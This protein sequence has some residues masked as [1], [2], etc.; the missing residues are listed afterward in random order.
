VSDRLEGKVALVTGANSGIGRAV[1]RRFAA[2]GAQVVITGR[3][4]AE[5]KAVA[6]EIGSAA[7]AV[8]ADS[9]S[10]E[11]LDSLFATVTERHGRLDIVVPNAGV[12]WLTPLGQITEDDYAGIFGT[13]VKGAIFTVQKALPLLGAGASVILNGSAASAVGAPAFSVYGA[14]KAALR[15]LVRNWAAELRGTGIRVNIVSPGPVETPALLGLGQPGQEQQTL[16]AFSQLVPLGRVAGPDEIAAA[17]AFVAS[18]DASFMHGA[19]L[20]IDGGQAQV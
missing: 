13:N 18:Q 1:A 5:L 9:S 7:L 14:S 19:E 11:D 4:E 17:F 2:E 6:D 12:G 16:E 8:R 20:F 10:Q 3:R 15:A